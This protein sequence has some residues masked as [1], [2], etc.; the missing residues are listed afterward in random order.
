MICAGRE[1]QRW[2]LCQQRTQRRVPASSSVAH[3]Q[4]CLE[5][6]RQ[7]DHLGQAAGGPRGLRGHLGAVLTRTSHGRGQRRGI[8]GHALHLVL[9][10]RHHRGNLLA[11]TLCDQGRGIGSRSRSRRALATPMHDP[12]SPSPASMSSRINCSRV[13]TSAR[14]RPT[15]TP[16]GKLSTTPCSDL[17]AGPHPYACGACTPPLKPRGRSSYL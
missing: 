7:R 1:K 6:P 11:G 15:S 12:A 17:R 3:L 8:S 10:T 5:F 13:S 14:H 2:D 9:G 16:G 4:S